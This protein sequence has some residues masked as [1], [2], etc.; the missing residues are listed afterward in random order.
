[1]MDLDRDHEILKK[2]K[3]SLLGAPK[4]YGGLPTPEPQPVCEQCLQVLTAVEFLAV[5][6]AAATA[7]ADC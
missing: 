4:E 7:A 1:M 3:T 6:A 2:K 5:A